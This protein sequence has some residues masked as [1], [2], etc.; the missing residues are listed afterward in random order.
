[1]EILSNLLAI[2]I[3]LCGGAFL[4]FCGLYIIMWRSERKLLE[5]LD[6]KNQLLINYTKNGTTNRKGKG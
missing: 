2:T 4:G 5:E 1:M 6:C 3:L